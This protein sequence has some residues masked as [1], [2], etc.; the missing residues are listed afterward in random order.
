IQADD[1]FQQIEQTFQEHPALS[2]KLL[3]LVNSVGVGGALIIDSIQQALQVLG[4]RQLQ[5]W[6]LLLLYTSEQDHTPSSLMQLAARRGKLME[7]LSLSIIKRTRNSSDLAGSAFMVGL[8]SLVDALFGIPIEE[9]LN[10]LNLAE[11]VMLAV[12]DRKGILGQ[13]L[14]LAEYAEKGDFEN[15]GD[16]IDI[17]NISAHDFMTAQVDTMQWVSRLTL[18]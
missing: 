2:L 4:M 3:R 10:G 5:N 17:M 8:L 7:L 6:V 15:L 16:K 1:S 9:A 12:I 11:E 13:I 18:A 14:R